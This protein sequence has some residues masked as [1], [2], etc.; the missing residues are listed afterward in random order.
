MD[1]D[2][3]VVTRE[4]LWAWVEY[5][6][7]TIDFEPDHFRTQRHALWYRDNRDKVALL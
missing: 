6:E 4:T 1:R 3:M 5:H 7:G 2:Q